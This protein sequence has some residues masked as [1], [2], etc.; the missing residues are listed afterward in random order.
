MHLLQ[1][2]CHEVPVM[3]KLRKTSMK[4]PV[5]YRATNDSTLPTKIVATTFH[6]KPRTVATVGSWR[7]RRFSIAIACMVGQ[8]RPL[9]SREAKRP[10]GRAPLSST[11]VRNF[12]SSRPTVATSPKPPYFIAVPRREPV[13][14]TSG[15]PYRRFATCERRPP[16][17]H[18]AGCKPAIR[19]VADLRYE[20]RAVVLVF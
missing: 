17:R 1:W 3:C 15:L 2:S 11:P 20:G 16:P 4:S 5:S 13:A 8:K 19:Q 6:G 9:D 14:W 7:S 12:V 10:E 18:A